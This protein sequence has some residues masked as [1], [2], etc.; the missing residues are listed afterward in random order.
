MT[1]TTRELFA[2]ARAA[3]LTFHSSD[4]WVC[5]SFDSAL[6]A[7]EAEPQLKPIDAGVKTEINNALQ[8][9]NA[10]AAISVADF[11]NPG[12]RAY[13]AIKPILDRLAPSDKDAAG[14]RRA[15]H[16]EGRVEAFA[17]VRTKVAALKAD[18]DQHSTLALSIVGDRISF[19]SS[20]IN[21][22]R[23]AIATFARQLTAEFP[24]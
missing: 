2:S 24:G 21:G 18:A 19:T 7:L 20:Y 23:D 22:Y 14:I 15:G 11:L 12:R 5:R 8:T 4:G 16:V 10:T 6:A 1:Q 13:T 9:L 17:E 3:I